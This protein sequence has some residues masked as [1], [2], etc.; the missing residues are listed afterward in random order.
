MLLLTLVL[1][2]II[3]LLQITEVTFPYREMVQEAERRGRD[4]RQNPG[5]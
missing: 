5:V 1:Q 3:K 2:V 4:D